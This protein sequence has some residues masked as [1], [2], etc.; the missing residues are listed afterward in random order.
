M[1]RQASPSKRFREKLS[2]QIKEKHR[3]LYE[4]GA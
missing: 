2:D 4:E 3:R 1:E